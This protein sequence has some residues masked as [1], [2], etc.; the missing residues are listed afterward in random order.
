MSAQIP[1]SPGYAT[2]PGGST[3]SWN[4]VS[5]QNDSVFMSNNLSEWVEIASVPGASS[6]VSKT[7]SEPAPGMEK[8]FFRVVAIPVP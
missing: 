8:R 6:V 3:L 2:G 5:G 7:V 1:A 4:S